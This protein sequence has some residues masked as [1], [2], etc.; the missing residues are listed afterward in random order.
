MLDDVYLI[1]CWQSYRLRAGSG[2]LGRIRDPIE[3]FF[4]QVS[5]SGRQYG[6]LLQTG[7]QRHGCCPGSW[8]GRIPAD[9]LG[10]SVR[11]PKGAQDLSAR[12]V[13]VRRGDFESP[14]TLPHAFEG[15]TQGLMVSSNAQACGGDPLA[16]HRRAI[17]AARAAGVRR[18][19]YT[20]HMAASDAA[21][22]SPMHHHYATE[23]MLRDSGLAWTA[24]RNGFYAASSIALMGNSL[25]P[26]VLGAPADGKVAWTA[27]A[28]LAEAAAFILTAEGRYDGPTPPFTGSQALDLGD[29][30]RIASE[31][32]EHPVHRSTIT[33]EDLR[34]KMAARGAPARAADLVL[35]LYAASRANEFASVD[36]TLERLLGRG[37]ISIRALLAEKLAH[38]CG[39]IMGQSLSA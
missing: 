34:A 13:R 20:S 12:G 5:L 18:I 30:A 23:A 3:Q 39:S 11:D 25:Q 28:D 36:P 27:H 6:G 38:L 8:I 17:D 31:L 19:V 15:A 26:G 24:L 10:A 14:D 4:Q 9:L 29:L 32:L 7:T 35:G 2:Q 33:D 1:S 21:A 37:P 16:R 22:F